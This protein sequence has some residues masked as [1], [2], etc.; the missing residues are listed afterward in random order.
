MNQFTNR[1]AF[2]MVFKEKN[3]KIN[4]GLKGGKGFCVPTDIT[5]HRK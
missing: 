3:F 2:E 1:E 5:G 4:F